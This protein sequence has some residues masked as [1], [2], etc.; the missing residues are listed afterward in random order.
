MR[1]GGQ[2]QGLVTRILSNMT[3]LGYYLDV[4]LVHPQWVFGDTLLMH[5]PGLM[6]NGMFL[7]L[8][9]KLFI[10]QVSSNISSSKFLKCSFPKYCQPD[11]GILHYHLSLKKA[12]LRSH[13]FKEKPW[14]PTMGAS[15][16]PTKVNKWPHTTRFQ[17]TGTQSAGLLV[18]LSKGA[19][20]SNH[21]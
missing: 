3:I 15:S 20:K 6:E 8:V 14:I 11:F 21:D 12:L 4:R 18:P 1:G 9:N 13:M 5:H 2:I 10:I 7:N 19:G 16:S 17:R